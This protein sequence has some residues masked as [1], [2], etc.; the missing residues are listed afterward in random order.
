[1]Y[2]YNYYVYIILYIHN[3]HNIYILYSCAA[4]LFE[5]PSTLQV[6]EVILIFEVH[7]V[8]PRFSA[9]SDAGCAPPGR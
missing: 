1:M 3:N 9:T 4:Q 8:Q 5:V 7:P 6:N 2:I